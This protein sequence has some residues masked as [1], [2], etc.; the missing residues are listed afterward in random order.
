MIT[1]ASNNLQVDRVLFGTFLF[2]LIG[3][4]T[5]ESIRRV[6]R[7]YASWRNDLTVVA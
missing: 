2:I 7:R 3:V 5:V 4:I 6:E 1:V